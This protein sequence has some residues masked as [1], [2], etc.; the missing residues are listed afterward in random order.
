[1]AEVKEKRFCE[2]LPY[3]ANQTKHAV[4]KGGDFGAAFFIAQNE[5]CHALGSVVY[6][7]YKLEIRPLS[8]VLQLKYL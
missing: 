6:V 2:Q 5:P 3:L 4:K 1:L 7:I 8:M